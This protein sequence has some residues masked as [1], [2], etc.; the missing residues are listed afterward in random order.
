MPTKLSADLKA[1]YPIADKGKLP[2]ELAKR[3]V[4]L[5]MRH[6]KHFVKF[7]SG[8]EKPATISARRTGEKRAPK[9]GEWYL[10]GAEIEAYYAANDYGDESPYH[11]AELVIVETITAYKIGELPHRERWAFTEAELKQPAACT[12]HDELVAAVEESEI[13]VLVQR[14]GK[15]S[16][17]YADGTAGVPAEISEAVEAVEEYGHPVD[18]DYN[19]LEPTAQWKDV[20][21][22]HDGDFVA[23]VGDHYFE[24]K[25]QNDPP[26]V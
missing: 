4:K 22:T 15:P 7:G 21:V 13:A 16:N 24:H 11:I 19:R 3:G 10:S 1:T 26:A 12:S 14:N 18:G 20:V 23:F 8:P 9:A 6:G 17:R 2:G 5:E 25:A